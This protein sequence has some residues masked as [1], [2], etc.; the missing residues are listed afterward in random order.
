[1]VRSRSICT[2][3]ATTPRRRSRKS[4]DEEPTFRQLLEI[5]E[6][7]ADTGFDPDYRCSFN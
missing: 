3:A 4:F 7:A 2:R 6:L 5:R 1:M